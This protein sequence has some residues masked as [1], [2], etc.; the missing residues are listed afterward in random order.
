MGS[1]CYANC[2]SLFYTNGTDCLSCNLALCKTC[3]TTA[4][5]CLSCATGLYLLGSSC[6]GG[7]PAGMNIYNGQICLSCSGNCLTC[8]TSNNSYCTTCYPN[9]FVYMGSCISTC[10]TYFFSDDASGSCKACKSP[11][12]ECISLTDCLNCLNPL[13]YL[14]NAT[15]ASSCTYPLLGL[16]GT[17]YHCS[18]QCLTCTQTLSTCLLCA[19][20]FYYF[21][22]TFA[23]SFICSFYVLPSSISTSG[24]K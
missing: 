13:F 4:D 8:L 18:S 6:L 1:Y 19:T 2:P 23:C 10:P 20:G 15:C 24:N 5:T 14:E 17:C 11:C 16:N 3:L 7:C 12:K 21:P 9:T 22:S